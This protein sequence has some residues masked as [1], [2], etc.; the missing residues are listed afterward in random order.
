MFEDK[1]TSTQMRPNFNDLVVH[2]GHAYGFNGNAL[3]CIDMATGERNWRGA[4]YG[5]QVL[6][7]SDQDLLLVLAEN[8]DVALV[9]ATPQAFRV[10]ASMNAIRG[11][12][13]NHPVLAGDVL[14]VRN[15]EEMAAY[16]M[17]AEEAI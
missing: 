16:R 4:R 10:R 1:W 11:K 12:T 2:E 8:G 9:E 15:M 7:L 14:L 13:W 5:G 17:P 6:L 3:V